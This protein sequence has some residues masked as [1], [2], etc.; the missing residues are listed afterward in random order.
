MEFITKIKVK[1]YITDIIIARYEV[2]LQMV[3]RKGI[4]LRYV[5]EQ[6]PELCFEAAKQN[7][8]ALR[9]IKDSR[10]KAQIKSQIKA[11]IKMEIT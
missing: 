9:F 1:D 4:Y 3:K 5:K 8:H 7:R 6:T 11:Q 10:L 2:D